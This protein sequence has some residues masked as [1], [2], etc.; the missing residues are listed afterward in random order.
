MGWLMYRPVRSCPVVDPF[1]LEIMVIA[2]LPQPEQSARGLLS[3]E[4]TRPE[5]PLEQVDLADSRS[6]P[7]SEGLRRRKR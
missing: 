3:L 2:P 4:Q 7:A 5:K 1:G 6:E